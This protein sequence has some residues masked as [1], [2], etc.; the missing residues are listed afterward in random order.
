M[1]FR[2]PGAAALVTGLS[3]I[4]LVVI[5]VAGLPQRVSAQ[6]QTLDTITVVATKTEEKA[7]DALAPVS[8]LDLNAIQMIN[9]KRV[10]ELLY[11]VPGVSAMDRGDSPET[12]INI[13]GMQDFGRV[14]VVIDGARQNYQRTGDNANGS[15]FL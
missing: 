9:P 12:S 2:I 4:V 8:V 6:T 3:A 7:I 13:R 10:N 14:A 1:G 11:N 5:L 15:F